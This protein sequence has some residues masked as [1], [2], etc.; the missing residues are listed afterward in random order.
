M[1][2]LQDLTLRHNWTLCFRYKDSFYLDEA[3][4]ER[5]RQALLLCVQAEVEGMDANNPE[6]TEPAERRDSEDGSS[7]ILQNLRKRICLDRQRQIE[8]G[9]SPP[10]MNSSNVFPVKCISRQMCFLSKFF[11]RQMCFLQDS[12]ATVESTL[13]SYLKLPLEEFRCLRFALTVELP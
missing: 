8:V 2:W 3:T 6:A 7:S 4:G 12:G 13:D 5:A 1:V 10:W 9:D 11:S